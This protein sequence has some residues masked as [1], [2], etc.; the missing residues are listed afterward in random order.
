MTEIDDLRMRVT[1]LETQLREHGPIAAA[2]DRINATLR[3]L[4]TTLAGQAQVLDAIVQT[5][6]TKSDLATVIEKL[7][8]ATAGLEM[9]VAWVNRQPD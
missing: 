9:V 3:D 1:A 2:I 4:T 5:M 8:R 7:D 6:I